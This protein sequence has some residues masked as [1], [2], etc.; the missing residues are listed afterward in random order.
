MRSEI[1]NEKFEK[2]LSFKSF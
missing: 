1:M 2:H